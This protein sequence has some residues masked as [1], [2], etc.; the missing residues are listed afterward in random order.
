MRI[1]A[2]IAITGML[3]TGLG[4]ASSRRYSSYD[5]YYGGSRYPST[6]RYRRTIPYYPNYRY[7]EHHTPPRYGKWRE[8]R[9]PRVRNHHRDERRYRQEYRRGR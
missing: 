4:C 9:Q 7:R 6:H 5:P 2:I 1:L 8:H 3:L